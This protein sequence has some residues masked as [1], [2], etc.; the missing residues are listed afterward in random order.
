MLTV[1]LVFA[2]EMGLH[3]LN[4][5]ASPSAAGETLWFYRSIWGT[6]FSPRSLLMSPGCAVL[7][8]PHWKDAAALGTAQSHPNRQFPVLINQWEKDQFWHI[9][10]SKSLFFFFM[11]SWLRSCNQTILFSQRHFRAASH[12]AWISF[13]GALY[14]TGRI[15]HSVDDQTVKISFAWKQNTLNIKR[16]WK[17]MHGV[18]FIPSFYGIFKNFKLQSNYWQVREDSCYCQ[19][20]IYLCWKL[21]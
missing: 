4:S 12:S 20:K 21:S 6:R 10:Y 14:P 2:F 1:A 9:L 11:I 7:E 15:R 17:M 3:F 5:G 18:F 8:T 19:V 13:C 16:K